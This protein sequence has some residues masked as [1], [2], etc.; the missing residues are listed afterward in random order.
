MRQQIDELNYQGC[1]FERAI[2]FPDSEIVIVF[3]HFKIAAL[4]VYKVLKN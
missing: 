2:Q 1:V 4:A 3:S